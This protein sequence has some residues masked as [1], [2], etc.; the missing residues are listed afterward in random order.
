MVSPKTR[1]CSQS[2]ANR[3]FA[4]EAY[5]PSLTV[6]PGLDHLTVCNTNTN[7]LTVCNAKKP[8]G[9]FM[10]QMSTGSLA[11]RVNVTAHIT[12]LQHLNIR[13]VSISSTQQTDVYQAD[14]DT[15][16]LPM[17]WRGEVFT[18]QFPLLLGTLVSHFQ[19]D[20][21]RCKV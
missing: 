4:R 13:F 14:L 7:S 1:L 19:N 3:E 16:F 10:R 8:P 11:F 12:A 5:C 20:R 6:P 2:D 18:S 15:A 21:Y 17:A 9:V